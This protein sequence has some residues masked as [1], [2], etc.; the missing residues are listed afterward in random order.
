MNREKR[1]GF[2]WLE[3]ERI[4]YVEHLTLFGL[5]LYKRCGQIINVCGYEWIEK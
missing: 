5:T 2:L 1:W 3:Y 4:G